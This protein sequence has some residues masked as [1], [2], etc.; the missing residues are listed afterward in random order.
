[1]GRK[2]S[3]WI[4]VTLGSLAL[5]TA[6][7]AELPAG[8]T[9]LNADA[10]QIVATYES[11]YDSLALEVRIADGE[12]HSAI[13]DAAGTPL[14]YFT[15]PLIEGPGSGEKYQEMV[16]TLV[17]AMINDPN[18]VAAFSDPS[19][20]TV[21]SY[22]QFME[23]LAL[24]LAG[25]EVSPAMIAATRLHPNLLGRSYEW[26]G[27]RDSELTNS[28]RPAFYTSSNCHGACGPGCDWCVGAFGGHICET[29]LFCLGHDT[30]CGAWSDF[31]DCSFSDCDYNY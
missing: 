15:V 31:F 18:Q 21:W 30:Y 9:I 27:T 6:A 2:T 7:V 5:A 19:F 3:T 26:A 29:N 1:M 20:R 16:A 11:P 23:E 25:S 8:L 12:I 10:D 28:K 14:T 4:L 17:K 24:N 13:S 22:V